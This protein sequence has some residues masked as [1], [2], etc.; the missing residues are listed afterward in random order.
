MEISKVI[1]RTRHIGNFI[2][3]L[4]IGELSVLW[5]S[6]FPDIPVSDDYKTMAAGIVC[7][8]LKHKYDISDEAIKLE[9]EARVSNIVATNEKKKHREQEIKS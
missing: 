3:T 1:R 8:I 7:E 9:L 6:L 4:T 5:K 2:C